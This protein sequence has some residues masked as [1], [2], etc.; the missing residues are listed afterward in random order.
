[1]IDG[2][3][4]KEFQF[5]FTE[6]LSKR[7]GGVRAVK[8]FSMSLNGGEIVGL[9]GPNGAG[10]TTIFNLITGLDK[11]DSGEIFFQHQYVTRMPAHKIVNLGISRTFQ[12]TRL[13]GHLSALDNVKIAYHSQI[14][15]NMLH[16]ALRLPKFFV[17]EKDIAEKSMQFLEFMGIAEVAQMRAAALPYGKRRKLELARALATEASLLLLDEP[18]AGLNPRETEELG[19]AIRTIRDDFKVTILLIEHD[20]RMVMN[21]CERIIVVNFGETIAVGTPAELKN[22]PR[23]VEAYLGKPKALEGGT[24]S[25]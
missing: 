10:K 8:N 21:L 1:V 24:C 11:P 5:F 23:V 7:F 22:N 17:V 6:G 12:N 16:A 9:I 13:L 4:K 3:I 20:M 18:A 25:G 14:R 15:Y 2:T 19:K